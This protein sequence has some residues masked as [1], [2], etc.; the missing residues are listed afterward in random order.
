M[1][2]PTLALSLALLDSL[3]TDTTVMTLHYYPPGMPVFRKQPKKKKVC[4]LPECNE[5]GYKDYCCKEHC[6]E[7]RR[8]DKEKRNEN[9]NSNN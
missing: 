4:A 7:H 9:K 6:L 8:R 5:R 1:K 3:D 2:K